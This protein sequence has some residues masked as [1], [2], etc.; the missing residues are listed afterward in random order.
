MKFD[1]SPLK[2]TGLSLD[3]IRAKLSGFHFSQEA[4]SKGEREILHLAESLLSFIDE[5][6][7]AGQYERGKWK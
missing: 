3:E 7:P 4:L 1:K 2:P 5:Q 6:S